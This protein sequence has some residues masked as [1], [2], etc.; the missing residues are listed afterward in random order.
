MLKKKQR[1]GKTVTE[2]NFN[3][4]EQSAVLHIKKA[5]TPEECKAVIDAVVKYKEN[6]PS[7][8]PNANAGCWRGWP[9]VKGGFTEEM[10]NMI[11]DRCSEAVNEYMKLLEKPSNTFGE[12]TEY[13]DKTR[14]VFD[15][16]FNLNRK[17]AEN[18]EHAHS[19][20]LASGVAYFQSTDT[21][22][23]EFLPMNTLYKMTNPAWPYN[24]MAMYEPSDGD[25]LIFPSYLLHKVHPN[26]NEKPRINMAFNVNYQRKEAL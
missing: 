4:I 5:F 9:H 3:V 25:I 23:I 7:F 8:D 19:G 15:A 6:S 10:N 11:I 21:G 17:G 16:W 1:N 14:Y 2:I 18:R 13:M 22:P 26:P 24:G 20:F 12:S